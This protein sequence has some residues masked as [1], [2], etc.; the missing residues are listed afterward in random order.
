[1]VVVGRGVTLALALA[2]ALE[3]ALALP[4]VGLELDE[5]SSLTFGKSASA[6]GCG[7]PS[8]VS[9]SAGDSD[10][11]CSCLACTLSSC[12]EVKC[13]YSLCVLRCACNPA[14][15]LNAP[16]QAC[17]NRESVNP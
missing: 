12:C 15:S 16:S 1:M 9:S 11:I 4:L 14:L 13:L 3:L 8:C 7:S 5:R 17:I 2:L 6:G 10:G